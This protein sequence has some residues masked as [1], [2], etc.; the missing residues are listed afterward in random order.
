MPNQKKRKKRE[1]EEAKKSFRIKMQ[2]KE[3]Y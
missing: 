2:I 3:R 1:I